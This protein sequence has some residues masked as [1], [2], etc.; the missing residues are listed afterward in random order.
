MWFIYFPF[1][2]IKNFFLPSFQMC[3]TCHGCNAWP[4]WQAENGPSSCCHQL[5]A[6]EK[7]DKHVVQLVV[8]R[9]HHQVRRHLG[10]G[11]YTNNWCQLS[12][13]AGHWT[14]NC[15][16]RWWILVANVIILWLINRISKFV[17]RWSEPLC[18]VW[19]IRDSFRKTDLFSV[20]FLLIHSR[21]SEQLWFATQLNMCIQ[22]SYATC[23][24]QHQGF[25]L[26]RHVFLFL[27]IIKYLTRAREAVWWC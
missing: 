23:H 17:S 14:G 10:N 13:R 7:P 6:V 9:G 2:H 26:Q 27:N 25:L 5:E 21:H 16:L 18:S 4:S 15:I 20:P 22:V 8:C 1:P 12:V 19:V 3:W 11:Y 24:C